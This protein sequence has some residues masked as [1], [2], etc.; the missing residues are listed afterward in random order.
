[1]LGLI[2]NFRGWEKGFSFHL[3]D[4][5]K[6]F[7]FD[8]IGLQETMIFLM[9]PCG[10]SLMLEML[11]FGFGL[12]LWEVLEESC[13]ALNPQDVLAD[14]VGRYFVKTRVS[15]KQNQKEYWLITVY[16]ATQVEDKDVFLQDLSNIC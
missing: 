6:E 11:T 7:D 16:G 8:F 1:M 10:G 13:V 9:F 4:L 5:I 14:S 12:P 15:D 2:M 3:R